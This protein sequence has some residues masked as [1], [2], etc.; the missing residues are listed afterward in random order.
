[1]KIAIYQGLPE[2]GA[3]RA[4]EAMI[5]ILRVNNDITIYE[6]VRR[7][8]KL[9]GNRL[10]TD[11]NDLVWQRIYQQHLAKKI[12]RTR[13]DVCLITHD[14]YLHSP[15]LLRYIQTPTLFLCQEPTRAFYEYFLRIPDDLPIPNKLYEKLNR[16]IRKKY[17]LENIYR[18]TEIAT[19]SLY[20]IE[21]V[22]R[23][24]G[25]VANNLYPGINRQEYHLE[26]VKKQKQ[27]LIVGNNEPQKALEFAIDVVHKIT[28]NRRP[29]LVV[30]SPRNY[31][32]S[33][34]IKLAKKG[35]VTLKIH[36]SLTINEMRR[37]YN[38]SLITLAVAHLEPFGLSAIESMACSTPVVAVNEGGFRETVVDGKTGLLLER[39]VNLFA[40]E[41]TKLIKDKNRLSLMGKRGVT[42]V[43][44]NF[45]WNQTVAK[46]EDILK[47][48]SKK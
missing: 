42:H 6:G 8:E 35:K 46:L 24:Y 47:Y 20:S 39:D 10:I 14:N 43:N 45:T 12:D 19:T 7:S 5:E 33:S 25:I 21:S 18:A 17:E 3:K 2:G 15:W 28:L 16:I 37:L 13:Y 27:I 29:V 26:S 41:I 30:A 44:K 38:Q 40:A 4:M 32:E 1:M 11:L 31:D 34:L 23:C 22:F 36:H 48:A 9:T